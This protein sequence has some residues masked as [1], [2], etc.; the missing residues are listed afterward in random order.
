MSPSG[1]VSWKLTCPKAKFTHHGRVDKCWDIHCYMY[2]HEIWKNISRVTHNSHWTE[3]E[4]RSSLS[5]NQ[6]LHETQY[7]NNTVVA[8]N[9]FRLG[10]NIDSFRSNRESE[11]HSGIS[12]RF[13]EKWFQKLRKKKTCNT[14]AN[15]G[16]ELPRVET[17][18]FFPHM[19][20]ER[21]N[22]RNCHREWNKRSHSTGLFF[23]SLQQRPSIYYRRSLRKVL[24]G[25]WHVI[26]PAQ[27]PRP[28][29]FSYGIS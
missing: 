16:S 24:I 28:G 22:Y 21:H 3:T 6:P 12:G 5:V 10:R 7:H 11:P 14:E 25:H 29:S 8:K 26:L 1:Q 9:F 17:I 15:W 23:T 19:A 4:N 2:I 20:G 13:H 27:N 18:T